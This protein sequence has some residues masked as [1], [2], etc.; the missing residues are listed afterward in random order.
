M[1]YG[2]QEVA[3]I[4]FIVFPYKSQALTS[5]AILAT[6][7]HMMNMQDDYLINNTHRS[8]ATRFLPLS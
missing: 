2:Q 8:F 4:H 3:E 6:V 5:L 7:F 1:I